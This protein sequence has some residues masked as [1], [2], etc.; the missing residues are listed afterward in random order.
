MVV[1]VGYQA[2]G[3]RGRSLLD[4]AKRVKIH[5][6]PIPVRAEVRRISAFSAHADRSELM[7][8]L[9][10]AAGAP[11]R[12]VLVHGEADARKGLA[13]HIRSELGIE[14]LTPRQGAVIRV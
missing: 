14:A 3:T 4:G 11:D 13:E 10:E 12:V 1:F 7:R 5:G 2:A 9:R 8:W 6:K